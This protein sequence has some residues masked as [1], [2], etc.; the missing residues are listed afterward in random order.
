MKAL[1]TKPRPTHDRFT[2][3]RLPRIA[4]SRLLVATLAAL[5]LSVAA[6]ALSDEPSAIFV[7]LGAT[8]VTTG[9]SMTIIGALW[10]EIYGV[11]TIGSIR[12]LS[13]ALMVLASAL[14]P[15]IMG[16]MIDAG[17]TMED[18]AWM[19]LVYVALGTVLLAIASVSIRRTL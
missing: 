17:V 7:F 15:G 4:A 14:S 12:A 19:A 18:M 3:S 10:A 13:S 11:Q 8:G 1:R 6:L 16:W 2:I 9:F 5:L